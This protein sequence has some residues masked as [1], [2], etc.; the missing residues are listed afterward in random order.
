MKVSTILLLFLLYAFQVSHAN[1]A[2]AI[3][4]KVTDATTNEPLAGAMISIPE[5]RISISTNQN[6]EYTL[7]RIPLKGRFIIEIRYIGY[8]TITQFIDF[9]SSGEFNFSLEPSVIEVHEVVITG[10]ASSSNN[11]TNSTSVSTIGK[12]EL[13]GRASN[14]I[15]DAIAHV[16]GVSQISTGAAISKPVIRGLSANRVVTLSNGVKQEGQ[17]WGDEHGIEVDQYSADRVEVLRGAASLLYGSDALGGVIN[18]I[19]ALPPSDGQIRGEVLSNYSTN[20]GLTSTSAMLQGNGNGFVWQGRGTYKNAFGY[21][22]PD[23]RIPNTGFKETDF[24]AMLGFNNS[25]GYT[26]LNLSSYQQKLGLPDFEKNP[27]GNYEDGNGVILGPDQIKSRDLLLPFQDVRHYKIA[28]NNHIL[29]NKG[30]LRSTVGFQN[31]QRRELEESVSD[32]SLFFDLKTYSYDFKYYFE[33]NNGWQ[34]VI[35]MAGAF[36]KSK[37]KA[38]ELLVPDYDNRDFGAF[39]YVKKEWNRTTLNAGLRFD[40]RKISG[41]EMQEDGSVKFSDFSNKFSNLSGALGFTHDLSESWNLKANLGSAFRAPN[42]SELSSNGV[43]EGTFRYEIGNTALKP[44]RSLYSDAALEFHNT[45]VDFHLNI[46]NNFINNYIYS[47]QLNNQTIGIEGKDYPLFNYVQDDANLYG[48]EA[49][50]TLHP[51]SLIHFENN[52]SLT[53][54][55]NTATKKNLPFMPAPSLRNELR[56]EPNIKSSNVK[57]SY[58]SIELENVFKQDYIDEEFET[59]TGAYSLI[60]ASVG[61]TLNLNSQSFKLYVSANNILDKNYVNHLNRLKYEGILNQGRNIAFGLLVPLN[62]VK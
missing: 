52:F 26:H 13:T 28:L 32:P 20:N 16:P 1:T 27:E 59:P 60:N 9:G 50:L 33:E 57:N 55:K 36:Q 46:Y 3:S 29:F 19:D 25:K 53:R 18:I 7:T 51:I 40:N 17:Q 39:G 58:F 15:I 42:I 61:T 4:G 47:R 5:L 54:G 30:R 44:E 10:T 23:G 24:G 43:H 41:V 35:G 14:N 49:G 45:K 31:N 2:A 56:I 62:L 22:T 34:R 48:F 11:R 38:E 12:N 8:K 6:G 37:N 21:N